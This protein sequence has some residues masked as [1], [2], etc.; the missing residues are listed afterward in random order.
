MSAAY[1]VRHLPAQHRFAAD[2]GAGDD[3]VLAYEELPGGTLDLQHTVVPP[4]AR[5]AGAGN[6]LVRAAVDY[7][8][9]H[10][11]RLVPTCPF[12]AAWLRRHPGEADVFA[13]AGA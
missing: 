12:V 2:V 4:E 13:E 9:A 5:G 3:A 7:A 11:V 1:H 6:A 8:R 10:G